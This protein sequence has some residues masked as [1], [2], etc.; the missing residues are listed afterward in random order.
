MCTRLNVYVSVAFEPSVCFAL[1]IYLQGHWVHVL[2]HGCGTS[3]SFQP[4]AAGMAQPSR[5]GRCQSQYVGDAEVAIDM[6]VG[7][8][9]GAAMVTDPAVARAVRHVDG[10]QIASI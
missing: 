1:S 4:D 2:L 10:R 7:G 3:R 9:V 6:H 5:L 8:H